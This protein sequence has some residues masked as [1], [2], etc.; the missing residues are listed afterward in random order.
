MR[1]GSESMGGALSRNRSRL[2]HWRLRQKRKRT[3]AYPTVREK[4]FGNL[5]SITAC[6]TMSL[7]ETFLPSSPPI[8]DDRRA[9]YLNL[10]GSI[11]SQLRDA[12]ARLYEAGKENQSSIARNLKV[13]RSVV[14]R[15]LTGQQN[16]TIETTADMVWVL[17]CSISVTISAQ[18][19]SSTNARPL[20]EEKSSMWSSPALPQA[21]PMAH[22]LETT[23]VIITTS[24]SFPVEIQQSGWLPIRVDSRLVE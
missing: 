10:V 19:P 3:K 5:S 13:G 15:R 20:S 7:E 11:E 1:R 8:V 4:M 17:G 6:K 23:P 22:T 2:L 14:H 16:M 24:R 9:V 18:T 21:I 12:Y